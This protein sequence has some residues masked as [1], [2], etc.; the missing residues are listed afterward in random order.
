MLSLSAQENHPLIL[1]RDGGHLR[2][3]PRFIMTAGFPESFHQLG[4]V[5]CTTQFYYI[6]TITDDF[7]IELTVEEADLPPG[8]KLCASENN[9]IISDTLCDQDS[10]LITS[11]EMLCVDLP[12]TIQF[13]Y[14]E[15]NMPFEYTNKGVVFRARK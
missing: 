2:N 12:F 11:G 5:S 6:T 14:N 1:C 13:E 8:V 3:F 9:I 7:V 15:H 4:N 10:L